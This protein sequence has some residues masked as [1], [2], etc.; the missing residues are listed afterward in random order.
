[1][2]NENPNI[3]M[4]F[5]R[6]GDH[7]DSNKSIPTKDYPLL[8][9]SKETLRTLRETLGID[10]NT[11]LAWSGD[12]KRSIDTSKIIV[13]EKETKEVSDLEESF[14]IRLDPYLLYKMDG[15]FKAFKDYLG[16]SAEQKKLF[17]VVV[18]KSD[19]FKKETG[20]DFTS[21]AD[22]CNAVADYVLRYVDILEKWE[23]VSFKYD[24]NSL[25]RVFCANEYFYASFRA[26]VE[27]VLFGEAARE[28]YV[29]WYE[30]NFERNE[31]RKHEEQSVTIS[32]D[33]D[34]ATLISLK[35]SYG[36]VAFGV[37][38]LSEIKN[39]I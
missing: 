4:Q 11:A 7:D 6:H 32:R 21:Y 23:K 24:T 31:E 33:A 39:N 29:A 12:N 2:S 36:E 15:N 35:D 19:A 22:M 26:K 10:H 34:K 1:M 16:L 5:V 37:D 28:K 18:E 25:F 38:Q 8:D 30:S 14:K 27:Q 3:V 17:R 9:E 13:N 20:Y